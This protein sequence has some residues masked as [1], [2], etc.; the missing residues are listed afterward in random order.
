VRAVNARADVKRAAWLR[1]R[2]AGGHPLS[3]A[4]AEWLAGYRSRKNP[5][6]PTAAIAELI[7]AV[8]VVAD[9]DPADLRAGDRRQP[10]WRD[11]ARRLFMLAARRAGHMLRAIAAVT[12]QPYFA[13]ALSTRRAE[14]AA[15][16]GKPI[17]ARYDAVIAQV[18]RA[19]RGEV[20][21]I[22]PAVH[23]RTLRRAPAAGVGETIT[24]KVRVGSA[25]WCYLDRLS[26]F[27][28]LSE[29]ASVRK[30]ARPLSNVE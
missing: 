29:T 19:R 15:E 30:A 23:K 11:D 8:T 21:A 9:C 25:A 10:V 27:A 7:A 12:G 18:E 5:G 28:E 2:K 3:T 24:V 13:A 17:A 4:Q 6:P 1:G 14:I 20:V 26:E 22:A 16:A